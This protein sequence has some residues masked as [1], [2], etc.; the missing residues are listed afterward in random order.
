MFF[1]LSKILLFFTFPLTWILILLISAFVKRKSWSSKYFQRVALIIFILFSNGVIH[2]EVMKLWEGKNEP[3]SNGQ[4][5]AAVVLGGYSSWNERHATVSFNDASDRLIKAVELYKTHVVKKIVL[6]GGSGLVTKPEEKESTWSKDLLIRLGVP[7]TAIILEDDSRNTHENALFTSRILKEKNM[8]DG[9]Y[10]L[11]TSA[12][13]MNRAGRCF[14]AEGVNIDELRVDFKIDD[15]DYV[16]STY[17][18]PSAITLESWQLL[19]K[20]WL[21]FIAYSAKGYF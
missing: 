4:Y 1:I 6:S 19:I 8:S 10:V 9:H 12:F 11:I 5:D 13:H 20:E 14:R 3:L 16:L 7:D 15:D 17:L 21:G 18:I 2:C